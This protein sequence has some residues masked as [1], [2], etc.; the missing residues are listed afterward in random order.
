MSGKTIFLLVSVQR[1][2]QDLTFS[3][4]AFRPVNRED[5]GTLTAFQNRFINMFKAT[6]QDVTDFTK[7]DESSRDLYD[8]LRKKTKALREKDIESPWPRDLESGQRSG[9]VID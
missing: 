8:Q 3:F 5:D 9:E 6:I 2:T 1:W 7:I 4:L